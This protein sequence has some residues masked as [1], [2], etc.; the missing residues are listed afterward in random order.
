MRAWQGAIGVAANEG[1]VS[2]AYITAV[3]NETV[4]PPFMDFGLRRSQIVAQMNNLSYGVTDF[5]KR[6]YWDSFIRVVVNISSVSEQR[7]ITDY[8]S[9]LDDLITLHQRKHDKLV[10]LKQA[11][12]QKMFPQEDATTPE[13]RFKGFEGDWSLAE[14]GGEVE[15]F[16]GLT[17]S[18]HHVRPKGGTLV[19]R[20]S[21][22]KN[23]ELVDA[24]NVYVESCV[25]KSEQVRIGD[26]VVVVRNGSRSLIGKHAP[27][28]TQMN[29][30]VIGAFMTGIRAKHFGFINALLNTSA[31]MKQIE[32]NT[33]ATINQITTGVFKKMRFRFPK[34]DE[35]EKI[36]D[37]FRLVDS[38]ISKHAI[39]VE[40][41]KNIKAACLDHMFA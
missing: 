21:N 3:P 39:Q 1:M 40:K 6:L 14:L 16:S 4:Y 37:Y 23:G 30:T 26:I 11:M 5:R 38:V 8:L 28:I 31:F 9:Q 19:L 29:D 17:Y 2:P 33:G 22:V 35:Q 7:K 10:A 41:L 32:E 12:L 18:P 15:F 24:D 13:I 36:G 27:V 20:S 25:A 34:P